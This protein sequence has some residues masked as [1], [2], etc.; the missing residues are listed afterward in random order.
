MRDG[1]QD[2]RTKLVEARATDQAHDAGHFVTQDS[3]A[4][5]G[6]GLAAGGEAVHGTAPDQAGARAAGDGFDN[7]AAATDAAIKKDFHIAAGGSNNLLQ[8]VERRRR[9]IE[10]AA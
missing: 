3:K 10:L 8:E 2:V 7:V 4:V 1:L 9:A 5:C 6:A